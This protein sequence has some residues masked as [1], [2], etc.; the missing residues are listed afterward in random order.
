MHRL[1]LL[2]VYARH[3]SDPADPAERGRRLQSLF[4]AHEKK[5]LTRLLDWLRQRDD[6]FIVGPDNPDLR[7]PTVSIL[8]KKKSL[9]EV[10]EK[11]TEKKLML[12]RGHFYGARPLMGMNIPIDPGVLR[13]SFLHYTVREEVDQLIDGLAAALD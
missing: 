10:F 6:I 8:P 11:L 13:F 1:P 2:P 4:Q 7:A 3:F 9:D 12:G 5:L